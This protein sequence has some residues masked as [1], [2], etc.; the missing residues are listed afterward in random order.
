MS[1]LKLPL[2]P[3]ERALVQSL[4]RLDP[5]ADEAVLA[6]AALWLGF[7]N[8]V[9]YLLMVA[10]LGGVLA[11]GLL[12][13]R[14]ISPPV[15]MIGQEWAM[16]LHDRKGGIPYGIALAG[17]ALWVYPSTPWFVAMAG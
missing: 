11:M 1:L 9:P 16:R 6:A 4:Q 10:I 8:V 12:M 14:A 17:A 3:L 13:F 5:S 7:A 2:G 15:W